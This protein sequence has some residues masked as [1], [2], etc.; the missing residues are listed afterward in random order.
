M[1]SKP[2]ER[3]NR[4]E[5]LSFA[6][7]VNNDAVPLPPSSRGFLDSRGLFLWL[8][9]NEAERK[10]R[11]PESGIG[12]AP[13]EKAKAQPK[14]GDR[15]QTPPQIL[16]SKV[17]QLFL[18]QSFLSLNCNCYGHRSPFPALWMDGEGCGNPPKPPHIKR[19]PLEEA[20]WSQRIGTQKRTPSPVARLGAAKH[21][22]PLPIS[23]PLKPGY[24]YSDDNSVTPMI[25]AKKGAGS[26]AF[27]SA[28]FSRHCPLPQRLPHSV[29]PP[30]LNPT[31][32]AD[33]Q[34][35]P[36]GK[37]EKPGPSASLGKG[38]FL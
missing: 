32:D 21:Q 13:A 18:S 10:R 5:T 38:T 22:Q 24:V 31:G 6:E 33:P 9:G 20:H 36:E 28:S 19:T 17:Q 15:A 37:G 14:W 16:P 2:W 3:L 26:L 7:P 29:S 1:K 25:R 11:S 30:P 35:M 23:I 4:E 12:K 27:V 8:P 34:Q